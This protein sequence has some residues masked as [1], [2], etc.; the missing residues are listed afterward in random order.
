MVSFIIKLL[1][2]RVHVKELLKFSIDF[3]VPFEMLLHSVFNIVHDL[4][5]LFDFEGR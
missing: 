2:H 1:L 5:W 4:V 3:F